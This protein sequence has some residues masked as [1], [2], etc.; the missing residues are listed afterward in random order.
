MPSE[1]E[2]LVLPVRYRLLFGLEGSEIVV[3]L[4]IVQLFLEVS[5]SISLISFISATSIVSHVKATTAGL[6]LKE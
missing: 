2:I 3:F 4:C 5:E 6:H 1:R